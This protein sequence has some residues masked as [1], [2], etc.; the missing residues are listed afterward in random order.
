MNDYYGGLSKEAQLCVPIAQTVEGQLNDTI[1]HLQQRLAA[2]A[3]AKEILAAHPE[4]GEF[5][6]AM[7]HV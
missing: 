3:K 1:A 5:M 7:K 6:D 2:A 4:I